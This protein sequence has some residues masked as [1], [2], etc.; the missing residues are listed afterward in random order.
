MTW[1]ERLRAARPEA[2]WVKPTAAGIW[3]LLVV[4]GVTIGAVNTGNNLV[5]AVLA[6]MLAGLLLNNVLGEW[7][8]R[9]LEV[10]RGLPG[11]LFAESPAAGRWTLVNRRRLGAAWRVEVGELDGGGGR[12]T[13]GRVDPGVSREEGAT[14]TFARRG[15]VRLGRV[16]V[17]SRF[18][19]GLLAR[20][21]EIDLPAELLVY[22]SPERAPPADRAGGP[23]E[24]APD[25]AARDGLGDFAGLRAW[26]PGDPVRRIHWPSSARAG[27]PLVVQRT[28]EQ[29]ARVTV[30]LEPADGEAG[31]RRAC[32]QVLFHIARG[33]AVGLEGAGPPHPP[34]AGASQRRLLLTALALLPGGDRAP[35]WGRP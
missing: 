23:G 8:L 17:G 32:G 24:G 31:V 30:C 35:S 15:P 11:E 12:V 7:N 33:D 20:W 9:G 26:H 3:Y 14:W 34:R 10:R 25:R 16:R 6:G 27:T 2:T 21:R 19:F 1:A 28:G 22:P 4:G 5:Y 13:F 18:P 29:G